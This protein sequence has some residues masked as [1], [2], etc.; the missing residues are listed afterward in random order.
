MPIMGTPSPA[1][2]PRPS[3][4]A[5]EDNNASADENEPSPQ[6]LLQK[7]LSTTDSDER[8]DIISQLGDLD[9][10]AALQTI[11]QLFQSEQS[12][13]LRVQILSTAADMGDDDEQ[14]VK[15]QK[16]ILYTRALTSGQPDDVR[17]T[18]A[19]SLETLDDARALPLWQQLTK[20]PDE[21][22]RDSAQAAVERLSQPD[23]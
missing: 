8:S 15:D 1:E 11:S 20:D 18:A 4:S 17:E 16:L 12:A 22:I 23:N 3:A 9:S 14:P 21:D 2:S 7:Y 19:D 10:T 13:E 5:N 6:A